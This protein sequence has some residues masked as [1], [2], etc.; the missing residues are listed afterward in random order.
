MNTVFVWTAGDV[1]GLIVLCLILL[2]GVVWFASLTIALIWRK[3]FPKPK[4]KYRN[5][6]LL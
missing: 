1:A 3:L 4:P 6:T 2:G 5:L